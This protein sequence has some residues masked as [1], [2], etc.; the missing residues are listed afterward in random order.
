MEKIIQA[1]KEGKRDAKIRNTNGAGR[2]YIDITE[3][4]K[5][6][7][8]LIKKAMIS[9]GFTYIGKMPGVGKNV[10]YV[11]YDNFIG[12][13]LSTAESVSKKLREIGIDAYADAI[14]D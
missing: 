5:Q 11:G 14:G 4:D 13:A 12:S 10:F 7:K 8:V 9:E 3:K 2:A 6:K 1:V